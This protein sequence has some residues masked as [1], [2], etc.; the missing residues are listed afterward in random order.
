MDTALV[1]LAQDGQTEDTRARRC[2]LALA[3]GVAAPIVVQLANSCHKDAPVVA[4]AAAGAV[5]FRPRSCELSVTGSVCVCGVHDARGLNRELQL[6]SS[7]QSSI[8]K[9]AVMLAVA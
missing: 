2:L 6:F 7:S 9:S 4:A 1:G 5:F 3:V 8:P